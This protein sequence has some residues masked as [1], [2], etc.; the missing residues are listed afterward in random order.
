MRHEILSGAKYARK[1]SACCGRRGYNRKTGAYVSSGFRPTQAKTRQQRTTT[2]TRRPTRRRE[3]AA[4]TDRPEWCGVK[5]RMTDYNEVTK[6]HRLARRTLPPPHPGLSCA[7]AVLLRQLQTGSLPTPVLMKYMYPEAYPTDT[8]QVCQRGRANSMEGG[9]RARV[10]GLRQVSRAS[11]NKKRKAAVEA[12]SSDGELR[13]R[14]TI[15]GRPAGPGGSRKAEAERK[16]RGGAFT[17]D[18]PRE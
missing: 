8:C 10:V 1:P 16:R 13:P 2:T 5:D 14:R 4:A 7:E 11:V 9:L 15:M 3:R 18:E 12:R 17:G 6:F